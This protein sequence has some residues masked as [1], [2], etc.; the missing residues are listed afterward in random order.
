MHLTSIAAAAFLGL[1]IGAQVKSRKEIPDTVSD[2]SVPGNLLRRDVI[3]DVTVPGEL[4]KRDE[5][6]DVEVPGDLL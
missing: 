2:I 6:T 3:A 4:L 5:A 1:V